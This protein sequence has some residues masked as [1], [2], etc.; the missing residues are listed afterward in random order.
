[1]ALQ[2][3]QWSPTARGST[4][5]VLSSGFFGESGEPDAFFTDATCRKM[6]KDHVNVMVNRRCFPAS[7]KA[8]L[9]EGRVAEPRKQLLLWRLRLKNA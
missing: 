6:F 5:N 2:Y 8:A 9:S 3:V 7:V 4:L 1:M